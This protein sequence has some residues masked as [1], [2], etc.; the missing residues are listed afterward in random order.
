MCC[1]SA[2]VA[3]NATGSCTTGI[4]TLTCNAGWDDCDNNMTNGCETALTTE[5]HCGQCGNNCLAQCT[6]KPG[7]CQFLAVPYQC[8]CTG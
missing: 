1:N 2:C 6:P 8:I 3:D 7:E 5:E 4:C